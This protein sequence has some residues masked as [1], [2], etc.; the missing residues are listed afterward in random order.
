MDVFLESTKGFISL[1]GAGGKKT[2]MYA[3]SKSI[4]GGRIALSSTTQMY[5]YD[6][7]IVDKIVNVAQEKQFALNSSDNVV[8]FHKDSL[9]RGRVAGLSDI[10]LEQLWTSKKFDLLLCKADGAR[11]KLIKGPNDSEPI[12]PKLCDLII[13]I[14]SIKVLG[15]KL[16]DKIAHRVDELCKMWEVAPA[17]KITRKRIACLMVSKYG[18]LKNSGGREIIPLINMV[19]SKEELRQA[20]EIAEMA[21]QLT[22]RFNKIVI[23]S[24]LRS[25]VKKVVSR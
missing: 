23:G 22:M 4:S 7:T 3:L 17:C 11:S 2:T 21:L 8:A 1:V 16:T 18:F 5:E 10:E 14:V 12:I 19:D 9:K 15:Q 24:M 6:R 20:V 13:P 25:E